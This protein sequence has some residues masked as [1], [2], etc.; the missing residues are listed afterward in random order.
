MSRRIYSALLWAALPLVLLR[1]LWRA[2]RQREYL[3]HVPE[4]FGRYAVASAERPTIWLHA[5]SV[6]ET[7]AAAPLV[8]A[9]RAR[10]PSHQILLTHTTPTGRQASEE[11]F[12]DRVLRAYLPFDLAFAVRR[13]LAH[14]QP[15]LGIILETELWPNLLHQAHEY[16]IPLALV[17]ARLSARSAARYARF[18]A[19]TRATL[20]T[21]QC[22]AAQSADDASRLKSLGAQTV[23]V[24]G[25]VKFDIT[26]PRE[27]DVIRALL[28][29]RQ[30]NT[31]PTFLCASTRENEEEIILDTVLPSLPASALIILVPRHPQRFNEVAGLLAKR[32][33]AFQRR[34]A[35]E[36]V[37]AATRVLLGDSMGEM[38]AYYAACD[39]AFIGG[40]LAP[41]GGQNLLEACAMGKPAIVGPHTFNFDQATRLA[42]EAGAAV[43]VEDAQTLA[44][45]AARLLSDTP[46]REQMGAAGRDFVRAHQGAT[47]RIMGEIEPLLAPRTSTR[48]TER[49]AQ[50]EQA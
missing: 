27:S 23:R 31:H 26:P 45:E 8:D 22:V 44:R 20:G 35:N 19:L 2:R 36:P 48:A 14:F 28:I 9:L 16:A 41:L 46:K 49:S 50:R 37:H 4:R 24:V 21:L 29:T 34:S 15:V 43:R 3:Q 25:N 1:L 13:F 38:F 47:A 33:L 32:G 10:Y 42:V 39:V 17:N 18:A 5:V 30:A 7:R 6:G 40:S 11:L 12:G